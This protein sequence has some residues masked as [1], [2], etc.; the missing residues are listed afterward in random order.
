MRNYYLVFS[1]VTLSDV[2]ARNNGATTWGI[3]IQNNLLTV[4]RSGITMISIDRG[5]EKLVHT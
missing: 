1:F 4:N 3:M 2:D 5:A